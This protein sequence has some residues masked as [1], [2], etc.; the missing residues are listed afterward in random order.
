MQSSKP[1]NTAI[2]I[3]KSCAAMLFSTLYINPALAAG[4]VSDATFGQ[5]GYVATDIGI[6]S[7][8]YLQALTIQSDGKL[9]AVGM[10]QPHINLPMGEFHS[11][12]ALVRYLQNGGLDS[13]F[14]AAGKAV[15]AVSSNGSDEVHGVAV[16][17][18]GKIVVVGTER[19]N[20]NY[21]EDYDMTVTRYNTNGTLDN[22]FASAG[23]LVFSLGMYSDVAKAVA[24]QAD[25]KILVGGYTQTRRWTVNGAVGDAYEFAL[26]R[27]NSNGSFDSTF[28]SSGRVSTNVSGTEYSYDRASAIKLQ[29][30]GKIVLA[31][32]GGLVRY[33]ANGSL[34]TNFGGGGKVLTPICTESNALAIQSDGKLLVG[35]KPTVVDIYKNPYGD[36][37]A[38]ARFNSNGTLDSRFGSKGVVKTRLVDTTTYTSPLYFVHVRADSVV[39]QSD[40]RVVVAANGCNNTSNYCATA[41]VRY[42]S[43]GNLDSSFGVGGI[44]LYTAGTQVLVQ[45][46]GKLLKFGLQEIYTSVPGDFILGRYLP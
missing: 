19:P 25:G 15:T 31:G 24:I 34:D 23:K 38:I 40:G 39:L 37:F 26:A 18:D 10:T 27:L 8:D 6:D 33:L 32:C 43:S 20:P 30:D 17:A 45:P 1:F 44:L 41:L 11:K 46:D 4:G 12:T 5:G 42:T 35:G 22:S 7:W 29:L 2:L 9:L 13:T 36:G 3:A 28:G 14:G 21:F 16:Q